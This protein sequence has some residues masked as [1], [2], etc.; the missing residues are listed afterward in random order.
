M[1]YIIFSRERI[2]EIIKAYDIDQVLKRMAKRYA[3]KTIGLCV[4][5]ENMHKA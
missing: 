3:N 5:R 2:L 1:I 4:C